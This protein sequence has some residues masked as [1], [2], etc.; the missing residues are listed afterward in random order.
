MSN[1]DDTYF[2]VSSESLGCLGGVFSNY[3]V[4]CLNNRNLAVNLNLGES[5][6][7]PPFNDQCFQLTGVCGSPCIDST[8]H[9]GQYPKNCIEGVIP[10]DLLVTNVSKQVE[11][12]SD[13]VVW[14]GNL[15]FIEWVVLM[16]L[17]FDT[18][19]NIL[20]GLPILSG[21]PSDINAARTC[22]VHGIA[23][24]GHVTPIVSEDEVALLRSLIG[25]T[26]TALRTACGR[27][28][29]QATYIDIIANEKRG[30][31]NEIARFKLWMAWMDFITNIVEMSIN[32]EK[33]IKSKEA[34]SSGTEHKEV[35]FEEAERVVTDGS[36]PAVKILIDQIR[37]AQEIDIITDANEIVEAESEPAPNLN[38][39]W[40]E[41]KSE[42]SI[43]ITK[44]FTGKSEKRES[45]RTTTA[46]QKKKQNP[47]AII[48]DEQ[49]HT[50][51][52]YT[53]EQ[54]S[55]LLMFLDNWLIGLKTAEESINYSKPKFVTL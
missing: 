17:F 43:T 27:H 38:F 14:G 10:M 41:D 32:A 11:T 12:G 18:F 31:P 29:L 4:T 34:A 42:R 51:K 19:G 2:N 48:P 52:S 21:R 26:A 36:E 46:G 35:R 49:T 25:R 50:T 54:L 40:G 39:G 23:V 28:S 24:L 20:R 3:L 55:L 8:T 44:F 1:F 47:G 9:G 30:E 6:G 13:N 16:V 45:S 33:E 5:V 22:H 15:H 7:R 53:E 37:L